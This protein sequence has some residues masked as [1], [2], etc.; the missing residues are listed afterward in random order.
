MP[1]THRI[2]QERPVGNGGIHRDGLRV[3]GDVNLVTKLAPECPRLGG[4]VLTAGAR[5]V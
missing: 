1:I 2:V 5:H 4:D 3:L